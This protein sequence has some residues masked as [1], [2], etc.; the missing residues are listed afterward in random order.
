MDIF[1]AINEI[2]S[3]LVQHQNADGEVELIDV[4]ETERLIE[5]ISKIKEAI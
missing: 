1:D 3:I 5:L 2:E 4:L